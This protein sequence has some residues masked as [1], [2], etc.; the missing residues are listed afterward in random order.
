[1]S[2]KLKNA[3]MS[4]KNYRFLMDMRL[5]KF[6]QDE[7]YH[8]EEM[9]QW[10]GLGADPNL[11]V[12]MHE[13]TDEEDEEDVEDDYTDMLEKIIFEND[14]ETL[15]R[16]LKYNVDVTRLLDDETILSILLT[17]DYFPDI[18]E[19][20][21][22]EEYQKAIK[23]RMNIVL[24]ILDY[25]KKHLSKKKLKKFVNTP[26]AFGNTPLQQIIMLNDDSLM[27]YPYPVIVPFDLRYNIIK[28]LIE[29]GADVNY[30]NE[31]GEFSKPLELLLTQKMRDPT[32]IGSNPENIESVN[33]HNKMIALLKQAG[34]DTPITRERK[35]K[36]KKSQNQ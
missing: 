26:N 21:T 28:T 5:K 1:M 11:Q 15:K 19:Y 12:R 25:A 20:S 6:L 33:R 7:D 31:E 3:Y 13:N 30:Q 23:D 4:T 14:L 10:I 22:D 35:I 2:E 9:L 27:F 8:P 24:F 29:A 16:F 36:K 34:A 18:N 32:T 17:G